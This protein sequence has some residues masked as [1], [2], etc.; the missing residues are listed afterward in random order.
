MITSKGNA[1]IKKIRQLTDSARARAKQGLF[2]IEGAKLVAEAPFEMIEGVYM[3]HSYVRQREGAGS[4]C[5]F[6]GGDSFEV[7]ADDVFKS[8][9]DT[10]NPQGIMA[11]VR[12][13]VY[14]PESLAGLGLYVILD[15]IRDPGNLGTIIRTAEA[16]GAGV[17]MSGT[18]V[19]IFNPK[20]IRSTMGSIFRVP[21][22]IE[23]TLSAI[24]R[25]QALGVT[26]CAATL[27]GSTEYDKAAYGRANAIVIGN[28]VDG[29]SCEAAAAA[30]LR[31][32]IPM[33]GKVESLN[34]A[35]SAAVLMYNLLRQGAE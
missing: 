26:V 14:T 20:V 33:K 18:C 30:D 25:L 6:M 32:R 1:K 2:V 22:L 19:D 15:D 21:F 13:P 35:V 31:V 3:S 29:V 12:R 34:A 8:L 23:D 11:V 5:E 4:L 17:I 28:E 16:A 10:I 9:S 24:K 7:I 27:N